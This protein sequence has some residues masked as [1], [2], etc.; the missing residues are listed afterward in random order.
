MTTLPL[1][2]VDPSASCERLTS[3]PG[4]SDTPAVRPTTVDRSLAAMTRSPWPPEIDTVDRSDER[5]TCPAGTSWVMERTAVLL[6]A[7]IWRTAAIRP[8]PTI[9]S[10]PTAISVLLRR[11]LVGAMRIPDGG[12]CPLVVPGR[13]RGAIVVVSITYSSAV[14]DCLLFCNTNRQ[15]RARPTERAQV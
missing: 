3:V 8:Q 12:W 6:V 7:F 11:G 9:N 14:V 5:M 4:M 15:W 13:V 10:T 1:V 2:T